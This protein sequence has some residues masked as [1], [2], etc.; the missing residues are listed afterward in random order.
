MPLTGVVSV[1]A[2]AASAL[3]P[4]VAAPPSATV[5]APP[6]WSGEPSLALIAARSPAA[7]SGSAQSDGGATGTEAALVAWPSG[8]GGL[9]WIT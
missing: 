5:T 9:I 4:R 3:A 1:A 2:F 6:A 8:G 7:V